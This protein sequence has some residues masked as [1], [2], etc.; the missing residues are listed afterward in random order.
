MLVLGM[1][2]AHQIEDHKGVRA[3]PSC[4]ATG[5]SVRDRI[6]L[7]PAVLLPRAKSRRRTPGSI[8]RQGRDVRWRC[9]FPRPSRGE[10]GSTRSGWDRQ[11]PLSVAFGQRWPASG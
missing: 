7:A 2:E 11:L 6:G 9:R 1:R 10:S 5:Q 3:A 8:L 4:Q